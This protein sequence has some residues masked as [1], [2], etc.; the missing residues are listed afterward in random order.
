MVLC[1]G[2]GGICVHEVVRVAVVWTVLVSL[3]AV[4]GILHAVDVVAVVGVV[5]RKRG[6]VTRVTWRR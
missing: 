4:V 6:W 3:R 5:V 1:F 2:R